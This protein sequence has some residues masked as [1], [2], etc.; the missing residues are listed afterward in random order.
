MAEGVQEVQEKHGMICFL[1]KEPCI[2]DITICTVLLYDVP[3]MVYH[4]L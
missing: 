4:I 1:I 2:W 3:F